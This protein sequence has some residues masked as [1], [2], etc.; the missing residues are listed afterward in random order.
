MQDKQWFSFQLLIKYLILFQY[1]STKLS[2]RQNASRPLSPPPLHPLL[3]IS[4]I[5]LWERWKFK[6][7]IWRVPIFYCNLLLFFQLHKSIDCQWE[8]AF[9]RKL[10]QRNWLRNTDYIKMF[11]LPASLL[12]SFFISCWSCQLWLDLTFDILNESMFLCS[13]C[14]TLL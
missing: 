11:C 13:L 10:G 8:V 12:N 1:L 6:H 5:L 14:V 9:H 3:H 2:R 7:D 4:V